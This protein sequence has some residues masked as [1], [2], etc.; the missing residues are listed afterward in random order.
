[1]PANGPF[2]AVTQSNEKFRFRDCYDT[3][4]SQNH[5]KTR[6]ESLATS[7]GAKRKAK[8]ASLPRLGFGLDSVVFV[9]IRRS[10]CGPTGAGSGA[11]TDSTR[12]P[13]GS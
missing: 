1:M 6:S 11:R 2:P 3:Q 10:C 12:S 9:S 7:A 4:L 13:R 8:N 5:K